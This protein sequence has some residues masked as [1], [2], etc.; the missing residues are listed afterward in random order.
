MTINDAHCHFFSS[1]FLELLAPGGGGADA[2]ARRLAWDP[3][4]DAASLADRWAAELDRQGVSRAALIASIPGDGASVA[5]AVARH[6]SRFVGFFMHNPAAQGADAM[7]TRAF[8]EWG[9]RTVCLFPAM[10]GYRLDDEVVDRVFRAASDRGA[11]VFA[12]CGVLTVGVRKKLGLPS[13][14]DLRLGDPLALSRTALGYPSVPVIVPHFGAGC[15][16]EALMAADQCPTIHFDTS[17][18]NGWIKFH[19]GL[20]LD[21]VFA[22]ALAIVGPSRL[23]FGTDSSFF[24]RG[25]QRP[26][27]EDQR[28]LLGALDVDQQAVFAGNF[29][30]LFP[31]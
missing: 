14:F 30:R 8:E 23:L 18:S 29:D 15:F 10:H 7:L 20:T 1:R 6:P 17:S 12:H 25:W 3:P 31:A 2:I 28:R 19:P 24:P 13:R 21:A 11:A 4:G 16:R 5:E 22:H 26:I 9:M 27:Y